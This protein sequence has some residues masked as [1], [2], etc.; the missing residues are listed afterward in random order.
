MKVVL[1]KTVNQLGQAGEIKEVA[2]GYALNYLIPKKI[3]WSATDKNIA[4]AKKLNNKKESEAVK[5]MVHKKD[6]VNKLQNYILEIKEKSDESGTFYA[7]IT[8]EKIVQELKNKGFQI[9]PQK[10]KL[11]EAIKKPGEYKVGIN[12][13]SGLQVFILVRAQQMK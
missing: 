9:A 8:K 4:K 11:A 10:I 2:N 5:Q 3:V 6:L 7:G 13:T 1:I 12:I